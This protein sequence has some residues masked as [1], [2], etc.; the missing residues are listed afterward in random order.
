[1]LDDI[2]GTMRGTKRESESL[3]RIRV[4]DILE[5]SPDP[6]LGYKRKRNKI[7]L[8]AMAAI[9]CTFLIAVT[10]EFSLEV[11]GALSLFIALN[12]YEKLRYEKCIFFYLA[13]LRDLYHETNV[14]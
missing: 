11:A 7:L 1:M 5:E 9:A 10:N 14:H 6:P 3:V 12:S 4:R 2:L 13:A 8:I